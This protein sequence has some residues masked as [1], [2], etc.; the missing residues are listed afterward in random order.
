[1]RTK[2][3]MRVEELAGR[4]G[5]SVD[6]IRFYQKQHLLPPPEREGRL[7]WYTAEHLE[8]MER[9]KELRR[10]GF[11]LAV[12]RRFLAGELDPADEPLA[13][14]VA[15]AA[16]APEN[17]EEFVTA[18]ELAARSGVPLPLIESIVREG[19]L[20]PRLHH[21]VP[22]YTAGDVRIVSAGLRLLQAG[23]PLPG[24]LEL[25][26]HHHAAVRDVATH[27]VELFDSAVRQPLRT[28]DLP[29]AEKAE[30]LVDAFRVLLPAVSELVAHHFRRVLLQVAQEHLESVGHPAEIAAAQSEAGRR[31]ESAAGR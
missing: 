25:A 17:D 22:R 16:A 12:I 29:E 21:G 8:R 2:P 1:M 20:V 15:E 10:R 19:L 13:A 27:A 23:L 11:T 31:L 28:A 26:R 6:T 30:R 5:V 14:A 4:A 9:V 7:A 24:L 18:E 3:R